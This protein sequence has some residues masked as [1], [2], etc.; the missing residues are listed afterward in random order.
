MES[1]IAPKTSEI[2]ELIDIYDNFIIDVYGV[3][4]NGESP[5]P[6]VLNTIKL[7][8]QNN[9]NYVFLSNAPRPNHI[10]SSRLKKIEID[11]APEKIFTSGDFFLKCLKSDERFRD[12]TFHLTAP[13]KN[14]HLSAELGINITDDLKV[15][16]FSI[17]MMFCDDEKELVSYDLLMRKAAENNIEVL[18]P[19]PD[20]VVINKDK[21][22]YTAGFF[23]SKY[24]NEFNGKVSYYGKPHK[25]IYDF[26]FKKL[27]FS[28]N[29][30]LAIG[31]SIET[32]IMG[33]K[34]AGIDS[35]MV[36]T[37]V[38]SMEKK[39]DNLF[40]QFNIKPEFLIKSFG[41]STV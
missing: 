9:K 29:N 36:R 18:C 16:D 35:V 32:D 24:E 20:K 12:K 22:R 21:F 19:N 38:H 14:E 8:E 4:H 7:L 31:D 34:N 27:N 30:T 37:G 26:L 11:I 41:S 23:A 28:T 33:A 5:Y 15:A 10:V 39:L 17:F 25:N 1:Q 2:E 13:E 40:N 6:G 3:L